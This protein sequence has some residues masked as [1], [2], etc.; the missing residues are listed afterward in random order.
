VIPGG[1]FARSIGAFLEP[2]GALL[3]DGAV[4]EILING[5]SE[6]WIEQRGVLSR[7]ELRFPNAA[8]LEA[9]LTNIS[10]YAGRPFD[11]ERPIL[12]AHLPDG[13]RIEAVLSPIAKGGPVV[14]IR[15]FSKSAVT[16]EKLVELG[17]LTPLAARFLRKAV[18]AHLSV[19]VSG[20][21]GTGKTSLLSAFVN[22]ARPSERI[23]VIEDTREID[24]SHP[25]VVYLEAR[26]ADERGRGRITIRDLL[27]ATLRLRPDRIV[28]GEVRGAEALDLIQAMTSGHRG[29]WTTV[30]ANGPHDALRRLETM[31]L[32]ADSGLPLA[33]VRAQVASA[34]DLVIQIGRTAEGQRRVESIGAVRDPDPGGYAVTPL[35]ALGEGGALAPC[36][37]DRRRRT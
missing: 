35:F 34:V 13:S 8:A 30:H 21:T 20:G 16:V 24:L 19:A 10:Q 36:R 15:R 29:S 25:H 6:I 32:M 1:A 4:S 3:D 12:E 28:I 37:H 14:A 9:A 26:S 2:I 11:R 31:T 17:S 33:A 22:S 23:V 7:T 5:P 27:R 18:A